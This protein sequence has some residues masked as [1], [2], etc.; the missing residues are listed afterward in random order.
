MKF[1]I[2]SLNRELEIEL[3]NIQ[4]GCM[5]R[6]AR[7]KKGYSQHELSLL[8]GTNPTMVGRVE[9][10]ENVS[11]WDK[12]FLISQQLDIDFLSLFN[13]KSKDELISIV[14]DSIKLDTKLTTE[15]K[16]YYESLKIKIKEGFKNL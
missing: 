5:L 14:N 2:V 10:F 9:R 15:K 6:F 3:L 11:G 1:Y 4:I 7:L 13:L 8:L 12:I 16:E